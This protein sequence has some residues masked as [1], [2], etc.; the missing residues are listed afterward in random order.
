MRGAVG[1]EKQ[2]R[3]YKQQ[4]KATDHTQGSKMSCFGWDSNSMCKLGYTDNKAKQQSTSRQSIFQKKNELSWVGFKPTTLHTLYLPAELPRQLS[5][6]GPN[7]VQVQ[8]CTLLN[9]IVHHAHC[10]NQTLTC[11]YIHIQSVRVGY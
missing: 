7:H 5:W 6:L 4:G 2:A 10:S 11:L 1:K 3:A 8:L 9:Y